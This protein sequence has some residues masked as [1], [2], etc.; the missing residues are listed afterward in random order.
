MRAATGAAGIIRESHSTP[1]LLVIS[2]QNDPPISSQ[3]TPV[4]R[5]NVEE[6]EGRHSEKVTVSETL[7]E[8]VLRGKRTGGRA[9]GLLSGVVAH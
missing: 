1:S 2:P 8:E 4:P 6:R 5:L 3:L 7:A 9:G